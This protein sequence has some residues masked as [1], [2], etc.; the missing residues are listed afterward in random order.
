MVKPFFSRQIIFSSFLL[1]ISSPLYIIPRQAGVVKLVDAG[2]SKSPEGNF[3]SVR[4]RPPAPVFIRVS[5]CQSLKPFFI[6]YDLATIYFVS[7]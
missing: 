1:D 2:D 3:M 6:R 5:G 7:G 4:F